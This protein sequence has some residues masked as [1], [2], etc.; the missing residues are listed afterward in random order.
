MEPS[1]NKTVAEL[2]E[3]TKENVPA[4]SQERPATAANEI[5]ANTNS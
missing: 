2:T 1:V 4:Q 5:G 3:W